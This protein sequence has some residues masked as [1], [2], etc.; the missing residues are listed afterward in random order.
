MI[1]GIQFHQAMFQQFG[2]MNMSLLHSK[3]R[4]FRRNLVNH[5][6]LKKYCFLTLPFLEMG[7]GLKIRYPVRP[8]LES[9]QIK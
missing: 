7:Q 5:I 9:L 3:K 8:R 6:R 1:L 2:F 4:M